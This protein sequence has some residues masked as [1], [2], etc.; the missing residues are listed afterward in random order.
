MKT[1]IEFHRNRSNPSST[2]D[3]TNS[4]AAAAVQSLQTIRGGRIEAEEDGRD[5]EVA[6]TGE[7]TAEETDT[8]VPS[9]AQVASLTSTEAKI[10]TIKLAFAAANNVALFDFSPTTTIKA[11]WDEWKNIHGSE[12]VVEIAEIRILAKDGTIHRTGAVKTSTVTNSVLKAV[13]SPTKDEFSRTN[14]HSASQVSTTI[15]GEDSP[16]TLRDSD[17]LWLKY[18]QTRR[19]A[20]S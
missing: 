18:A 17:T 12:V 3:D 5:R 4:L 11:E 7:N 14:T 15:E 16:K 10:I 19:I 1:K 2:I 6:D 8:E 9:A 13:H 20:S